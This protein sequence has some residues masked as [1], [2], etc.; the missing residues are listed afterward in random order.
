MLLSPSDI[1]N[2]T[3]HPD[4][5]RRLAQA[6]LTT[7]LAEKTTPELRIRDLNARHAGRKTVYEQRIRERE[8]ALK[9]ARQWHF[10]RKSQR[11]PAGQKPLADEDAAT[12]EADISRQLN[13][14]LPAKEKTG[15]KPA[16]QSLPAHLPREETV[17]EP[18]TGC[19]R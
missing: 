12:D 14:L 1:L 7:T 4:E 8:E 9:L 2:T 19:Y 16:R 3:Q 13:D 10:G 17:L 11:L 6:L 5:L 18:Q 15:K